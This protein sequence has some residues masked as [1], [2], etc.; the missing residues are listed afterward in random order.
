MTELT[1]VPKA[2]QPRSLAAQ[3]LF[4]SSTPL[5]LLRECSESNG[6]EVYGKLEIYNPTGS[7]KDRESEEIIRY[8]LANDHR[9]LAIA[10]TGNAAISLAFYSYVYALECH[11][12]ISKGIEPERLAH[13]QAYHPILHMIDGNYEKA[14]TGCHEY[15][16][17]EGCLNCNPGVRH[18]K[19]IGDSR[20]G[21]ELGH[22]LKMDY[23][24]CPTNNGTLIAGIWTGLRESGLNP[25]MVAAVTRKSTLAASIAGF[26][27]LEEPAL[28]KCI[29]ES[30][31]MIVDIDDGEIAEATRLLLKDGLIVEGA[32]AASVAS[33]KHLHLSRD[34]RI[35]CIITGNGMKFPQVLRQL[36]RSS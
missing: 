14:V 19:V 29:E 30:E 28:S 12:F 16:Q 25:R 35:C 6:V 27:R 1:Q 22:E 2:N 31:G 32:A 13:I 23:V 33:V 34:S 26:H 4:A 24:A 20:I 11:V 17:S 10:S 21:F 5:R 7:H 18:E 3:T 8:A 9:R 36:L 15:S